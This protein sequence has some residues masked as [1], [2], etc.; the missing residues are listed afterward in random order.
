MCHLEKT[1]L[2]LAPMLGHGGTTPQRP[3]FYDLVPKE[4]FTRCL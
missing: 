3:E 1:L 4:N 2:L